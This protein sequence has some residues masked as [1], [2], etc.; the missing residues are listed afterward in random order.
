M[1]RVP[2]KEKLCPE[3]EIHTEDSKS[4]RIY[5][6]IEVG[7]TALASMLCL[8][9]M[10]FLEKPSFLAL[11]FFVFVFSLLYSYSFYSTLDQFIVNF[12]KVYFSL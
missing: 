2:C 12:P 7:A 11:W 8:L 5:R 6:K 9:L 10:S 1:S 4:Y 3:K